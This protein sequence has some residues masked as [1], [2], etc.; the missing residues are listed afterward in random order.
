MNPDNL[1]DQFRARL[2][3]T[4][5]SLDGEVRSRLARA[6][7]RALEQTPRRWPRYGAVRWLATAGAMALVAV[8]IWPSTREP[9]APALNEDAFELLADADDLELSED[10]EFYAWLQ[11][12]MGEG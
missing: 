7:A 1:D 10:L 4:A 11:T 5:D 2:D 6:R 8:L 12:R 3:Q 9:V